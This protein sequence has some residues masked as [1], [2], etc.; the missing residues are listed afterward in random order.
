MI[1]SFL[2]VMVNSYIA[3]REWD[4]DHFDLVAKGTSVVSMV[5]DKLKK[6]DQTFGISKAFQSAFDQIQSFEEKHKVRERITEKTKTLDERYG[7]TEY[8][9]AVIENEKVQKIS[10]KVNETVSST[11]A[12]VGEMGEE[13]KTFEQNQQKLKKNDKSN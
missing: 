12:T 7:V 1:A 10:K 11:M 4:M 9:N 5:V 8:V 2:R 6:L 3:V 13:I